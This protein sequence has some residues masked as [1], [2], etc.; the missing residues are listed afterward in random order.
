M[1]VPATPTAAVLAQV[2]DALAWPL[3]LVRSDGRLLHANLAGH[4]LL[5]QARVLRLTAHHGVEPTAPAGR[6]ALAEALK[7]AALSKR[8]SVLHWPLGREGL[9]ATVT[10]L[11]GPGGG[12]GLLLLAL[13]ALETDGADD[14][15][16][17]HRL[18]PAEG[19]VMRRLA[20][21]ESS[22]TVALALGVKPTTVRS[23]VMAIRRKTGHA[24]VADL[25]RALATMPR[26]RG[27]ASPRAR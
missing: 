13:A 6:P 16:V 20:L 12:E 22:A 2:A 10:P 26:L 3:L 18:T 25:L 27:P 11:P 7:T 21:G 9:T 15:S 24:S 17:M 19:R 4:E 5:R 23:Q 1:N 8:R 14:F